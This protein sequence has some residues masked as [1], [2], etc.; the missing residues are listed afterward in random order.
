MCSE[1]VRLRFSLRLTKKKKLV[2]EVRF[3]FRVTECRI[4]ESRITGARLC[5]I[6]NRRIFLHFLNY[7]WYRELIFYIE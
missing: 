1:C 7:E 4:T 5:T 6:F 2:I 3:G